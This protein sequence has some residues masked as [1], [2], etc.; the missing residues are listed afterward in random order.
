MGTERSGC[1]CGLYKL[2][3]SGCIQ[4]AVDCVGLDRCAEHSPREGV[5]VNVYI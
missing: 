4:H 5:G 1:A 2:I 3:V